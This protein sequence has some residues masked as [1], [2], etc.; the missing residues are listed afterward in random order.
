M[1][2]S[3]AEYEAMEGLERESEAAEARRGFRRPSSA[4]P[5]ISRSFKQLFGVRGEVAFDGKQM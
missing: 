3:E 2:F 1:A 4:P 5:L